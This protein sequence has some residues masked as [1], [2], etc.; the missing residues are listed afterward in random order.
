MIIDKL[1]SYLFPPILPTLYLSLDTDD[2]TDYV[3]LTLKHK[4]E[5]PN[6]R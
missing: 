3:S 6:A 5:K 1:L 2:I 4:E